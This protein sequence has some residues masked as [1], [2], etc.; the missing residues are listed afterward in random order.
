MR[1]PILISLLVITVI[2]IG[3]FLFR[4]LTEDRPFR[5]LS[6][7]HI[8]QITVSRNYGRT[9]HILNEE[10]IIELVKILQRTVIYN[11]DDSHTLYGGANLLVYHILKTDGSN[12]DVMPFMSTIVISGIGYNTNENVLDELLNFE[13]N[14]WTSH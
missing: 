1:N 6:E 10:D 5:S 7:N 13:K 9:L 14:L 8:E 4:F 11:R 3:V 2:I 12:V